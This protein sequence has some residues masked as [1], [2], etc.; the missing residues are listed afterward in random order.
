VPAPA[1]PQAGAPAGMR[2]GPIRALTATF[3]RRETGIYGDVPYVEEWKPL[4]PR[5][6]D[7]VDVSRPGP[8]AAYAIGVREVTS[9]EFAEFVA[10]TSYEPAE[11]NRFLAAEDSDPDRPVTYV[12]VDDARAYAAWIGA[13]LPTEDEWQAAGEDGLLERLTPVVWN[14]TESEHSDGRTR[15][16]VLKGGSAYAAEGSDW[17][18]DGGVREPGYSLQLLLLGGGLSRSSRIG[19]RL[20]V[21]LTEDAA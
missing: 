8:G 14:W 7:F 11:Q 21:D 3:R 1:A 10:A 6:H 19:F 12:D 17:Y 5:L 2:A 18:V 4:P 20:A 16:A 9:R 13:R 15:F